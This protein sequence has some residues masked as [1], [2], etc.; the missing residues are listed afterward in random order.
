MDKTDNAVVIA[1]GEVRSVRAH[2]FTDRDTGEIQDKGRRLSLLT[3]GGFLNLSVPKKFAEVPLAEG[4]LVR[5]KVEV[6]LWEFN[7]KNGTSF[8]FGELVGQGAHK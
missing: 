2:S 8:I 6:L 3:E 1:E 7:G 5:L 4:D